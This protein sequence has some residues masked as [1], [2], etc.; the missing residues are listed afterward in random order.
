M[1]DVDRGTD[2]LVGLDVDPPDDV[3][4]LISHP[5]DVSVDGQAIG[6]APDVE[7]RAHP[8]RSSSVAA[9]IALIAASE[10]AGYQQP[11]EEDNRRGRP[12]GAEAPGVTRW[13]P[14]LRR[15]RWS[16]RF[17]PFRWL[18]YGRVR[19]CRRSRLGLDTGRNRR[20][21]GGPLGPGRNRHRDS[22]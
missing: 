5:K 2:L 20:T 18:G 9:P 19:R 8:R 7:C 3:L 12:N 4:H 13:R 16:R 21:L 14:A 11:G 22:P 17:A 1:S 6:S 15:R 10:D